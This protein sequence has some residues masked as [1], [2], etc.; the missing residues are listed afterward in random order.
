MT[1]WIASDRIEVTMKNYEIILFDLDG[2]LVDTGPGIFDS[3]EYA[4]D[5]MGI[6]I[7]S[8]SELKKFVGPPLIES[9]Q[10][11]CGLNQEQAEL[12][13]QY[14]REY[15]SEK[16]LYEVIY[17]PGMNELLEKLNSEGKLLAV[18]TSK[19]EHFAAKLLEKTDMAKYFSHICGS[20]NSSR[21][22]KAEVI[23]YALKTCNVS[24]LRSAVIVGDRKY[25]VIGAKKT[26]IDSIGVL[27]GYGSQEEL[28]EAG[29]TWI[30]ETV[31][32]IYSILST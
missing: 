20:L 19:P 32:D 12:G 28:E 21:T 17:Y 6:S 3:L 31:E 15:Y 14:Y 8:R 1:V 27:F 25:D 29:A 13:V 10:L 24:K 26:G 5:K 2:T 4:M 16:G 30:A 7:M 22:T 9:F 23:E 11:F 18:A